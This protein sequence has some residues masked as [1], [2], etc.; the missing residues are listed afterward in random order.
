MNNYTSNNAAQQERKT[1]L[2]ERLS[3]GTMLETIYEPITKKSKLIVAKGEQ[4]DIQEHYYDSTTNIQ[5]VPLCNK[6]VKNRIFLLPTN[7]GSFDSTDQLLEDLKKFIHKYV[8]VDPFFEEIAARFVLMTWIYDQ[9]STIP[10]LRILGSYGT[11]KSRLLKTLTSVC[12]HSIYLSAIKPANI[13]RILKDHKFT[14]IFD[15][16]NFSKSDLDSDLAKVLNCGNASDGVVGRCDPRTHEMGYFSS[17]SPKILASNH[18]FSDNALESRCITVISRP[19]TRRDIPKSVPAYQDWNEAVELRNRLLSYRL[20]YNGIDNNKEI[21]WLEVYDAR[22][23]EIL[24]PIFLVN[25]PEIISG[26]MKLYIGELN[27]DRISS[28]LSS[29]LAVI[30]GELIEMY[31]TG[32]RDVRPIDISNKLATKQVALSPETIGHQLRVMGFANKR[33]Q[34]G[35]SYTIDKV[36]LARHAAIYKY[37]I[38]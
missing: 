12:Y 31:Q 7:R 26:G 6:E 3:D 8:E 38:S 11:G 13:Y 21:P 33:K 15:E 25:D 32:T 20:K 30:T 2:S 1:I 18:P 37:E 36:I 35:N 34:L 17:F 27:A 19:L 4:R 14:Q 22:F 16:A 5:Y 24:R 29:P 28:N 10:Y 23:E 9:F